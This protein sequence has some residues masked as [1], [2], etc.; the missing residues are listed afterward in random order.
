MIDVLFHWFYRLFILQDGSFQWCSVSLDFTSNQNGHFSV[1]YVTCSLSRKTTQD[2]DRVIFNVLKFNFFFKFNLHK[3]YLTFL[4]SWKRYNNRFSTIWTVSHVTV[5]RVKPVFHE[6]CTRNDVQIWAVL[7]RYS[8][9]Q[10]S[11]QNVNNLIEEK[12]N[13]LSQCHRT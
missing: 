10:L 13:S 6:R 12:Q 2:V 9:C 7:S 3:L 11:N 8:S 4:F 5:F 1:A